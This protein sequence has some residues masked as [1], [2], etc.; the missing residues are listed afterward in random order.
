MSRDKPFR[1]SLSN[2]LC[3]N[4]YLTMNFNTSGRAIIHVPR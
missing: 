4:T 1:L 3:Q 2:Y